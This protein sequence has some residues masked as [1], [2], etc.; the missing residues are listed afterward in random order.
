[1]VKVLKLLS[2]LEILVVLPRE[3]KL[4]FFSRNNTKG[5]K[6][7]THLKELLNIKSCA[8]SDNLLCHLWT[9]RTEVI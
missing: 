7:K 9:K 8:F 1:M 6:L 4:D 2:M 5:F 3:L